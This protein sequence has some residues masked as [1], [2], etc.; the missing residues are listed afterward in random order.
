MKITYTVIQTVEVEDDGY[1]GMSVQEII[2]YERENLSDTLIPY[3]E[4]N[5]GIV[6]IAVF[7][8]TKVGV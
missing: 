2:D 1:E 6:S 7:T 8:P 3:I 4:S 5:P